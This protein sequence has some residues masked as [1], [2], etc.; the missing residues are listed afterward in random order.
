MAAD[1]I[2]EE[3][4]ARTVRELEWGASEL[5][6]ER[7]E[8]RD[9]ASARRDAYEELTEAYRSER[10][11]HGRTRREALQLRLGAV[12]ASADVRE[13]LCWPDVG[14]DETTESNHLPQPK[15]PMDLS[16]RRPADRKPDGIVL[17]QP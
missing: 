10:A 8:A 13:S 9:A 16:Q 17:A 2:G 3:D 15:P 11:A 6:Q 1:I 12:A 14:V 7:D 5:E 4:L